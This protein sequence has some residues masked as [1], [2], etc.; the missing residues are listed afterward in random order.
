MKQRLTSYL[1]QNAYKKGEVCSMEQA[2]DDIAYKKAKS[3]L[4][5]IYISYREYMNKIMRNLVK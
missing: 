5:K 2:N 1:L 3:D 4:E